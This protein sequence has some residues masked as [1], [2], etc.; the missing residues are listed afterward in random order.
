MDEGRKLTDKSIRMWCN[1][2]KWLLPTIGTITLIG[3]LYHRLDLHQ[4]DDLR[5]VADWRVLL[6]AAS[7]TLPLVLLKTLKW[8][9]LLKASQPQ[10]AYTLALRSFLIGLGASLFTPVRVGE[11]ARIACFPKQRLTVG[12]LVVVDKFIDMNTLLGCFLLSLCAVITVARAGRSLW[13]GVLMAIGT[14]RAKLHKKH[15][16]DFTNI[17]ACRACPSIAPTAPTPYR[18]QR[19][20]RL[21]LPRTD[22]PSILSLAFES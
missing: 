15:K 14:Y 10:T 5:Q 12:T 20:L 17:V 13:G 2:A 9:Y 7:L 16:I 8:Y 6:I 4:I 18:P 1:Q 3:L 11:L 21:H 22:V 19:Q